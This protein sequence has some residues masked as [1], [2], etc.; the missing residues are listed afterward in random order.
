MEEHLIR[1]LGAI[2]DTCHQ[3]IGQADKLSLFARSSPG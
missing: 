2:L 3:H 1:E